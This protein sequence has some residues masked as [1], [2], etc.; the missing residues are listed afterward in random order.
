MSQITNLFGPGGGGASVVQTLTGNSGGAVGPT[1]GN[2]NVLGSGAINVV[3]TPGTSTLTI[4]T[5]GGGL[6][7]TVETTNTNMAVNNG[8]I[9]N[10]GGTLQFLLPST[11]AVGSIFRVTGINN[12]NGWQITQNAGQQ[13]QFGTA[14]TTSGTGGSLESTAT[15]DA[16]ELVCTVANTNFVVLSS[17][18]NIT[19]T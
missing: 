4:S 18:G 15:A 19:V 11:A 2:I 6:P 9:A 17:V 3:G 10:G 12:A 5:S 13:I 1:G 14:A 7:W 16:V 8:Y